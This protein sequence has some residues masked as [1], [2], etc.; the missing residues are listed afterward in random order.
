MVV[1]TITP[2]FLKKEEEVADKIFNHSLWVSYI[3]K[4][5]KNVQFS[6]MA[7]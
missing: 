1:I 5:N 2:Y 3:T 4:L 6:L 7:Q